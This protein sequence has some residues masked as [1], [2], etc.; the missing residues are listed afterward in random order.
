MK[1]PSARIS[2]LVAMSG[3]LA[4]LPAAA[5][6]LGEAQVNSALGQPLRASIA[7]ALAPNEQLFGSCV[8][9]QGSRPQSDIPI[10]S[11]AKITV[12]EGV[13]SI[14]GSNVI[15]DPL[16]SMRINV[17]C[18][19]TA[20]LSRE[21]MLFIDPAD[22][23]SQLT[24]AAEL[25][26]TPA[27]ANALPASTATVAGPSATAPRRPSASIQP[28]TGGTRHRVQPGESLSEI[29][30]AI[31]NRP[32]GLWAAVGAIFDANPD[33]FVDHDPNKLKA[34]SW[35]LI[36]DFG[37]ATQLA[38][39]DAEIFSAEP[40]ASVPAGESTAYEAATQD[41]ALR[42]PVVAASIVPDAAPVDT[43]TVPDNPYAAAG[44]FADAFVVGIPDTE[45]ASPRSA[46]SSPNVATASVKPVETAENSSGWLAWFV[47]AGLAVIAALLFFGHRLR[48]RFASAPIGA[49]VLPERRRPEADT[50]RIQAVNAIEVEFQELSAAQENAI[51]DADLIIGTGLKHGRDVAVAQD[52]GFAATTALDLE[53]P[54]EMS[55]GGDYASTTD[56][57][58]PI[59]IDMDSI[60]ESEVL[61]ETNAFD[62]DYDMSVI[63]DA[64][65]M[66]MPEDVTHKDLAAVP[67]DT[68]DETLITDD[69]T[70]SHEVDY[71]VLEQDYED[72]F[73][74]TQALNNEIARAAA[75]LAAHMDQF[76]DEDNT[77]EM[78]MASV[79][80]LDVTAQ[81]PANDDSSISDLDDTGI[82]EA[83]TVDMRIDDVTVE[84]PTKKGK[85]A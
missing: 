75:E 13:I 4:T 27:A 64:T 70:V 72:E 62:D 56:I 22:L 32:V 60:L 21:Y 54:E 43:A 44:E 35:L 1:K 2:T 81:L 40:L 17:R 50:Q 76:D 26:T 68:S 31:V 47:G 52:F 36:P 59:N 11:A 19:Y 48:E 49:A 45:L 46:S 34:G 37:P 9:L 7:Y 8:S 82:N 71:K 18:P 25:A 3:G 15:R 66:P 12:A 61:P 51:L 41:P 16:V 28:I 39:N 23:P 24:P 30:Q 74:A 20:N 67:L 53:L 14:A 38:D 79:A 29:A 83:V 69:Y 5:L 85:S 33:A 80:A 84:M 57:I 73:T 65:K 10:V 55:S 58:P 6:E 63:I 77:A 42:E 78:S